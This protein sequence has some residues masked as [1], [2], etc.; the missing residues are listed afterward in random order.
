MGLSSM[1]AGADGVK[2]AS[3]GGMSTGVGEADGLIREG[4]CPVVVAEVDQD[5]A[6]LSEEVAAGGDVVGSLGVQGSSWIE[7]GWF[8]QAVR[9]SAGNHDAGCLSGKRVVSGRACGRFGG[10]YRRGA[11]AAHERVS[12]LSP[13]GSEMIV[14]PRLLAGTVT[15]FALMNAAPGTLRV[16][17]DARLTEHRSLLGHSLRN[18]ATTAVSPEGLLTC[19]RACDHEPEIRSLGAPGRTAEELLARLVDRHR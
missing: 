8:G 4:H 14:H 19:L 1:V 5:A 17:V 12:C 10:P 9:A 15:P 18:D 16:V 3:D 6:G 2:P 13:S 7:G 11:G